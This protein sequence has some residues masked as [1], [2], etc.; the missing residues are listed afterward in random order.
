MPRGYIHAP[1]GIARIAQ[2]RVTLATL[3][4]QQLRGI[5]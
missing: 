4:H 5:A 1:Q 2:F 3:D